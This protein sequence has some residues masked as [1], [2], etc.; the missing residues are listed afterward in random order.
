MGSVVNIIYIKDGGIFA[1][2]DMRDFEKKFALIE[3]TGRSLPDGVS[4]KTIG[5]RR[6]KNGFSMLFY[7][8]E[9]PSMSENI[10][11]PTLEDIMVHVEK[12]GL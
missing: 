3:T 2:D 11:T 6:T 9:V 7:A 1:E 8:K 4:E 12:E 5:I 10:K